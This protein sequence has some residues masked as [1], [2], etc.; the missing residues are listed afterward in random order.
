MG[1]FGQKNWEGSSEVKIA[2]ILNHVTKN[3]PPAFIT[4]GNTGSFE[5][6]GKALASALQNKGVPV[7]SL[8]FDKNISGELAHEFQ[9]KMN[10]PAGLET[11]NKVLE[12]LSE[13][14]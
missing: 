1:L 11:F 7:D 14:K 4:D 5:E 10:T 9:F 2:S 8:F 6:Q 12:F 3:Y 13:N